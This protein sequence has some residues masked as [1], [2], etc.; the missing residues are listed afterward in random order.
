MW[1][2]EQGKLGWGGALAS[3]SFI[4]CCWASSAALACEPVNNVKTRAQLIAPIDLRPDGSFEVIVDRHGGKVG[5]EG[6]IAET[7]HGKAIRNLGG[8][9]T[10]QKIYS[11]YACSGG[12][13][14][15]LFVDCNALEAIAVDGIYDPEAIPLG[16]VDAGTSIAM[17]QYPKGHLRFT[18]KTTVAQVEAIARKHGYRFSRDVYSD[19]DT[20]SEAKRYNPYQG[21]K[22]FYPDSPGAK[23]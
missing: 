6:V 21:C 12:I 9:R 11:S 20:L 18:E 15:L 23:R 4:A 3:L 16:G 2:R 10:G 8:G 22:I 7:L 17:I 5:R 19:Y 14:R 13:E 1:H